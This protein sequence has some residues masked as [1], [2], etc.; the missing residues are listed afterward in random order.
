MIKYL[1]ILLIFTNFTFSSLVRP[2]N[3]S[4]LSYTHILFEWEQ[5]EDA[6]FY[7]L[8][9]SLDN[10]FSNIFI[11]T[12]SSSLIHIQKTDISWDSN[13]F[14]R[15]KGI[16]SQN[17]ELGWSDTYNF[18]TGLKRTNA[19]AIIY[20]SANVNDGLTIFSSFFDYFT[21]MIDS[22][23]YEIWNTAD[24]NF[25]YYTIDS[26]GKIYGTKFIPGSDILPGVDY[27]IENEINWSLTGDSY[28]HHEFFM[29]PNG[30]YIGIDESHQNG[31]IPEDINPDELL[32]FQMIGYPT[33][34]S[35]DFFI[36][37]WV[38]D[39]ITEWNQSGEIVWNWNT[40]DHLDWLQDYDLLGDLWLE[41]FQMGRHDW[42]GLN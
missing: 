36:F 28:V 8:Q 20:D 40:F 18:S 5:I 34:P 14:W 38:G 11:E 27:S 31:P 41:A 4:N 7:V 12:T 24:N 16:D 10:S 33:Y 9:I 2:L 21:A 32:Q 1:I 29:L 22:E 19:Q 26:F 23:G 42:T 39:N 30:N 25:V 37:P 3:N 15:V 6:S 35:S 13:Y 17:N